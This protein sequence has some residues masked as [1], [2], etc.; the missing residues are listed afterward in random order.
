MRSRKKSKLLRTQGRRDTRNESFS[1][2]FSCCIFDWNSCFLSI[3]LKNETESNRI[4]EDQQR[5]EFTITKRNVIS[6]RL[7][8]LSVSWTFW[9]LKL[10]SLWVVCFGAQCLTD[11]WSNHMHSGLYRNTCSPTLWDWMK[12]DDCK[13]MWFDNKVNVGFYNRYIFI[14]YLC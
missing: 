4:D 7:F 6:V 13:L 10:D 5:N 14:I 11:R 1:S 8:S 12:G 3:F 9:K 2:L